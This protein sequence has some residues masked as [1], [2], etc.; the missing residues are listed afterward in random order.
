MIPSEVIDFHNGSV[1][2]ADPQ[3]ASLK[4]A[5]MLPAGLGFV[6]GFFGPSRRALHDRL[7]STRVVHI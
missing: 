1:P 6:P 3:F 2:G 5:S 4:S 7:A